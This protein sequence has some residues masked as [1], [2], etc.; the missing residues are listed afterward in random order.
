MRWQTGSSKE[1]RRRTE[2]KA[3][4]S[5]G[6]TIRPSSAEGLHRTQ[7]QGRRKL[8]LG[9]LTLTVLAYW[10]ETYK[11]AAVPVAVMVPCFAPRAVFCSAQN[12]G[13]KASLPAGNLP[14]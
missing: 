11:R 1:A 10:V 3:F 5:S 6:L 13:S 7:W 12:I 14:V 2:I 4:A 9:S 8:S